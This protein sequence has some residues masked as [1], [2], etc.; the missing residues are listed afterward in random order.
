MFKLW[1][2]AKTLVLSVVMFGAG[3]SVATI[4]L[5]YLPS[6]TAAPKIVA[7]GLKQNSKLIANDEERE[8][9]LELQGCKRG[10]Q[11]L[12]CNFLITSLANKNRTIEVIGGGYT[13]GNSRIID[14][15]GNEYVAKE[16]QIGN[17]K[18]TSTLQTELISGIPTKL[19]LSFEIPQ[20][21]TKFSV[22]EA[23]ISAYGYE[24]V[25]VNAQFR[26]V[27]LSGSQASNPSIPG[28]NCT[29][30]PTNP[31]KPAKPR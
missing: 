18:K 13:T 4:A 10:T 8:L 26:D 20:Q 5:S 31:K 28:N 2:S 3:A 23:V 30:P 11:Q 27:N 25:K 21:V 14:N 24:N 9:K 6:V 22:I 1:K 17:Q 16:I 15:S 29:C 12:I 19:S 7:Q